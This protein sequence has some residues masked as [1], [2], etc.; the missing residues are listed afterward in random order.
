MKCKELA[1][2]QAEPYSSADFLHGPIA[3]VDEGFPVSLIS[4]GDTFRDELNRLGENLARTRGARLI[5]IGDRML[6]GHVAGQDMFIP[7]PS[8]AA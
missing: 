4:M 2:I 5:T 7:V 8:G 6:E 3:I 1:N